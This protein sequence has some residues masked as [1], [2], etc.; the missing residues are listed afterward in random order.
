MFLVIL[1]TPTL[2]DFLL[3]ALVLFVHFYIQ[4]L[5]SCQDNFMDLMYRT[6]LYIYHEKYKKI[7][8]FLTSCVSE[9]C[10][11]IFYFL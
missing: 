11:S 6:S 1:Y 2:I 10:F 8:L 7:I 9:S 5:K 4:I 3:Q